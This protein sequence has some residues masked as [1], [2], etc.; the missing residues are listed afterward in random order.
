MAALA[1]VPVQAPDRHEIDWI[2]SIPFF[3]VHLA[4]A[5]AIHT[6]VSWGAV[7]A[8]VLTYWLRSIGITGGYHRYFAHRTFRTS[9]TFQFVLALL[10]TLSLQKGVLR[11][12]ALHRMHHAH[13]DQPGDVHSPKEGVFWSHVGWILSR[14]YDDVS[15]EMIP[16]YAVYPELRWLDRHYLV[17]FVL[18]CV[19]LVGLGGLEYL[20][21]GAFI[22]TTLLWH[23]TFCIN[24]LCHIVGKRRYPTTDTSKNSLIL[25]LLTGGE[26][27]HNNHHHYP[28]S[29]NQGF[30]WWEI[31]TTYYALRVLAVFGIVRDLR[32]PPERVLAA[33]RAAA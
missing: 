7:A 16:D 6:G 21:W 32:K 25:A 30:Y 15:L 31:D 18:M 33:G 11:W 5:L 8:L 28:N 1:E 4:C 22:S 3:G 27:W 13:S 9:R 17:P 14:E 12:A 24:S 20:V 26:G 10:G 29:V 19:G 23:T 2:G